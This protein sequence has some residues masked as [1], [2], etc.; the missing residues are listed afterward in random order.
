MKINKLNYEAYIIDYLEDQLSAVDRIEFE[1]YI[2]MHPDVKT[3]I[4]EYLQAPIYTEDLSM[5][6]NNKE[7]NKKKRRGF[8]WLILGLL[9]LLTLSLILFVLWSRDS[10]AL[11][12][13][14]AEKENRSQQEYV[15]ETK[16]LITEPIAEIEKQE[17]NENLLKETKQ[18]KK[19]VLALAESK[20]SLVK[21][22]ISKPSQPRNDNTELIANQ[23]PIFTTASTEYIP[24]NDPKKN[25]IRNK[26]KPREEL[27]KISIIP[28]LEQ[29]DVFNRTRLIEMVVVNKKTTK[30]KKAGLKKLFVPQSYDDIDFKEAFVSHNLKSAAKDIDKKNIVPGQFIKR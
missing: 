7:R 30:K 6:Y 17:E 22:S 1:K 12:N 26:L 25:V 23:D 21:N 3:E 24:N 9:S 14:I 19:Q 18:T 27:V 5:S 28:A 29:N 2:Q 20:I 10:S 4:D 13:T 8:F 16:K 15:I 11:N